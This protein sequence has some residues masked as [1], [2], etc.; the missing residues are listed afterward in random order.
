MNRR[1]FRPLPSILVILAL[2][3]AGAACAGYRSDTLFPANARRIQ[4]PIF[5]N[6]TFY[7]QIELSLT[8]SVCDELR[9]RPGIFVVGEG[10]DADIILRGT[11][12][13]VDQRVLSITKDRRATESSATTEVECEVVDARTEKVLKKFNT[14]ERIDFALQ[15]GEGLQTAQREA[16]YELARKIV[17][18]MEADW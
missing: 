1:D 15:T 16:F 13:G 7:R 8:R 11:I 9:V 18:E 3:V 14:R 2:L 17:F 12:T 6:E 4:V 5:E 10:G